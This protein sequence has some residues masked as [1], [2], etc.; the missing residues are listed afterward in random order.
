MRVGVG[1]FCQRDFKTISL[2]TPVGSP[3]STLGFLP[4]FCRLGSIPV[5]RLSERGTLCA[6]RWASG[7]YHSTFVPKKSLKCDP[8]FLFGTKRR[9][10]VRLNISTHSLQRGVVARKA[11]GRRQRRQRRQRARV[12][13]G[14]LSRRAFPLHLA[15]GTGAP[16][17]P[18]CLASPPSYPRVW[19]ALA[20]PVVAGG[21]GTGAPPHGRSSALEH[22]DAVPSTGRGDYQS[23]T[24][25]PPARRPHTACTLAQTCVCGAP[26][27]A[28]APA[29]WWQL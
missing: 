28:A 27:Q 12:T 10:L 21:P 1:L 17:G 5:L 16:P 18:A 9:V 4:G 26:A 3:T 14:A 25:V 19:A 6:P 2:F 24:R 7:L 11:G 15:R 13:E 8:R 22:L 20:L 29:S 23:W